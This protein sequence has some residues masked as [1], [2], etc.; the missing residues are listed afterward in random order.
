MTRTLVTRQ[1]PI[2]LLA[3]LLAACSALPGRPAADPSGQAAL[4]SHRARPTA[5]SGG[6][7]SVA[8]CASRYGVAGMAP[9]VRDLLQR[10]AA[11][12]LWAC[13][14]RRANWDR[15]YRA[16]IAYELLIS[17]RDEVDTALPG[18]QA[19]IRTTGLH[20]GEA[21]TVPAPDGWV[22]RDALPSP[23]GR[24]VAARLAGDGVGWWALDGSGQ[25][26]YDAGGFDLVWHPTEEM[27]AFVSDTN[28]VHL[29]QPAGP[30]IHQVFEAPVEAPLRFPYWALPEGPFADEHRRD[31]ET[32]LVL[33]DPEGSPVGA[34][35]RPGSGT[36]ERF[37]AGRVLLPGGAV[38]FPPWLTQPWNSLSG[39][40]LALDPERMR[41][42]HE[43]AGSPYLFYQ[44]PADA[45]P[46]SLTWSPDGRFFAVVER[47]DGRFVAQVLRSF[48][49]DTGKRLSIP[50]ESKHLAISDD[51]ITS[52]TASGQTV[53]ARNHLTGA[54]HTWHLDGEIRGIRL[55]RS[56]LFIVLADR[57]VVVPF[58]E[59]AL[60]S[61][62]A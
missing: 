27:F 2:W 3:M 7:P 42:L 14:A 46:V 47:R 48:Q 30:V 35:L 31:P 25:E 49:D 52:F 13:A 24:Y 32:V 60:S 62:R 54:E 26:R 5:T 10:G 59:A 22:L 4:S 9:D 8:D 15:A 56:Q 38:T 57:V 44:V 12:E 37:E 1:S 20:F 33:A 16:T 29:V 34:V 58:T 17:G 6:L 53:S 21:R 28:T 41:L 45:E 43:D 61:R 51:G 11:D 39:D 50:L 55:G 19:F 36:W 18:Y 40:Y 23:G